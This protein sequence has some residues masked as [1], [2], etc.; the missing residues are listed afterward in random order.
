MKKSLLIISLILIIVIVFGFIIVNK[1]LSPDYR[2]KYS[3]EYEI[4]KGNIKGGVDILY[5]T[6][7]SKDFDIGA[8]KYGY[9][10][11]KDPDK[12]FKTLKQKYKKGIKL[13][14]KEFKLMPISKFNYGEYKTYG[15]Q[16]TNGNLEIKEQSRFVSEFMDIYE[17]SYNIN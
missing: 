9:A 10:V 5:L 2:L 13:I 4:G 6:S 12:A 3:Q 17:N 11:F 14:Q 16:V 8:N 1:N 7:K 15:C